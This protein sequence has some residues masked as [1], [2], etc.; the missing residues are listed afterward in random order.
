MK[1][2]LAVDGSDDAMQ[3]VAAAK[4]I[5]GHQPGV[6]FIVLFVEEPRQYERAIAVAVSAGPGAF[7]TPEWVEEIAE[8]ARTEPLRIANLAIDELKK[9]D[10]PSEVLLES[11]RPAERILAA[12]ARE[13]VNA[14]VLGRRGIHGITRLV[15]GSV[16]S[17]VIAGAKVPVLVVPWA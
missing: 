9:D 6:R 7:H 2:L 14:I 13:Q 3:A 15:M 1:V 4:T 12:A 16:S 17:A 10:L 5:F 11:G 8:L